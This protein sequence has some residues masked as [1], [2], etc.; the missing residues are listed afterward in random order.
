MP[1]QYEQT[2]SHVSPPCVRYSALWPG[3]VTGVVRLLLSG[4]GGEPR[5][6]T[7]A[8]SPLISKCTRALELLNKHVRPAL[9]SCLP[10]ITKPISLCYF[11]TAV[12]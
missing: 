10:C 3:R 12:V 11:S 2:S 1:R 7:E 9:V 6:P 4:V 5:A 8:P